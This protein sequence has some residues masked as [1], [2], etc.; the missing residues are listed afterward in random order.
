MSRNGPTPEEVIARAFDVGMG[1]PLKIVMAC[2]GYLN[3][4]DPAADEGESVL[5][6]VGIGPLG[7]FWIR[8]HRD[9]VTKAALDIARGLAWWKDVYDLSRRWEV[10]S[11]RH[12]QFIYDPA[13]SYIEA[14]RRRGSPLRLDQGTDGAPITTTEW[15][16]E[17]NF[18]HP[19]AARKFARIGTQLEAESH[20]SS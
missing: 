2:N 4:Y 17:A 13:E 6:T 1:Q 3:S 11:F 12:S 5:G 8:A 18:G 15:V 14:R 7:V 10:F 9:P 19:L 20:T 16:F